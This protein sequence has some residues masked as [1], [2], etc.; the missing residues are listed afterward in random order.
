MSYT[1]SVWK[2]I[3]SQI[4]IESVFQVIFDAQGVAMSNLLPDMVRVE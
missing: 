1:G 4:R 2:V 3:S